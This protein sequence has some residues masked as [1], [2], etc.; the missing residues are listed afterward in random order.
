MKILVTIDFPPEIGGIQQYLYDRVLHLYTPEDIVINGSYAPLKPQSH[1]LPCK[2]YQLSW[3][4]FLN[5][6]L[7][8]F[9]VFFVLLKECFKNK[10]CSI[11][12]GNIYSA[13]PAFV[14]SFFSKKFAYSVYCYGSE[15]LQL[16]H[17]SL[18]SF[19]LKSIIRKSS[20]RIVISQFTQ[21]LLKKANINGP[22]T[23]QPPKIVL[24]ESDR[25]QPHRDK[26]HFNILSIGRFV[27]HK[28][29]SVLLEAASSLTH[30]IPWKLI[31]AGDGP[32]YQTLFETSAQD[33]FFNRVSIIKFPS[34]TEII[35]LYQD[36]DLFIFPSLEL[37]DS[38]EGFGIVLL[39]AMAYGIPVIASETGGIIDVV[40]D[41][42]ALLVSPG[43]PEALKKAIISLYEQPQLRC[44][45][46][47]NA[48]KRV[49]TRF[50]W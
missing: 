44:Q 14:L 28:G 37:S 11:E 10:K 39:E 30:S 47:Q 1:N 29:H 23:L 43:D 42:C 21:S 38:V 6:K 15:L 31:I 25:K 12:A 20:D 9:P 2:I 22:Y 13:I 35:K 41:E 24:P 33:Q 45:F 36:A 4:S 46:T 7:N 32:L 50:S 40:N 3:F 18:K 19:F 34:R 48:I 49:K 17:H 16:Q 8:L 27:K 5:K 26:D